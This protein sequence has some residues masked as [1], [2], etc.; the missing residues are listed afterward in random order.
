MKNKLK[1][2]A[3]SVLTLALLAVPV[4]AAAEPSPCMPTVRWRGSFPGAWKMGGWFSPLIR[5][6]TTKVCLPI[7][8]PVGNR[9]DEIRGPCRNQ[10]DF[11][12]KSSILI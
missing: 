5:R 1:R 11:S 9:I 3:A 2:I 10:V 4:L 7:G 12:W 6:W 8:F